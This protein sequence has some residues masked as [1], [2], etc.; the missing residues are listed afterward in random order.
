MIRLSPNDPS[1]DLFLNPLRSDVA[2]DELT[3]FGVYNIYKQ[4]IQQSNSST[5]F[6]FDEVLTSNLLKGQRFRYR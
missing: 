4:Q 6:I 1:S 2:S 5:L 3:F